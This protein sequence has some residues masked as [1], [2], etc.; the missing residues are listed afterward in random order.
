M[1][2]SG[3]NAL[4]L[5]YAPQKYKE[6]S[7]RITREHYEEE[8]RRARNERMRRELN[9]RKSQKLRFKI[10]VTALVC[11]IFLI[12]SAVVLGYAKISSMTLEA[13]KL[14]SEVEAYDLE[15]EALKLDISMATDLK[16]IKEV[17]EDHLN[18]SAAKD[19]QKYEVNIRETEPEITDEVIQVDSA[20]EVIRGL[21]D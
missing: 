20:V 19:Y 1:V 13:N 7:E 17:A 6:I 2:T 4:Q 9:R 8:R 21:L 16:H 10:M 3:S 15:I 11:V 5:D 14:R 18:M 12:L